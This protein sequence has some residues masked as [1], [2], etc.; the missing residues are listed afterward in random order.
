MHS[1]CIRRR[2]IV[3]GMLSILAMTLTAVLACTGQPLVDGDV[4]VYLTL[5]TIGVIYVT[6]RT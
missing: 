5:A 6:G 1:G 3:G 4:P 2:A